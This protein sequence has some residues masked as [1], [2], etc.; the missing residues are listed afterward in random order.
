MA[1]PYRKIS[2]KILKDHYN[3]LVFR[4]GRGNVYLVGG[5]IRDMVRG[6]RS[7]DRDYIVF[8]DIRSFVKQIQTITGGTVVEFKN[9]NMIRIALK[10][11]VT[12]DFSKAQG[13]LEEDLSKRDFTMNAIAWSPE[14]GFRDFHHGRDD[15]KKKMIRS[16]SSANFIAD[17]LRML[18][19]YRFAAE[20]NASIEK[21]TRVMIKRLH[22]GIK[23]VSPERITLEFFKLLNSEGSA[24]YLRMALSDGV[25]QDI[26][27]FSYNVL[28]RSIRAVSKLERASITTG[29]TTLKVLLKKRFS[30]TLTYKGLL[31]L[32]SVFACLD[33]PCKTMSSLVLSNAIQARIE[34]SS[35]GINEVRVKK[36]PDK[37]QLFDIFMSAKEASVDSMII[38]NRIDLLRDYRRFLRILHKGL[39]SSEEIINIS[40]IDAGPQRGKIIS[41]VKKAQFA[42]RLKSKQQAL[43]MIKEMSK[44]VTTAAQ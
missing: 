32:E 30:Q 17:P 6:V 21:R 1:L 44:S 24:K 7:Y 13:S 43:F 4:K 27:S 33:F 26:L 2:Q 15:I 39:L 11:G 38:S 20:L 36:N 41:A 42:G 22:N 34:L 9:E 28:G 10:E 16:L 18:R 14:S 19:A 5:F 12:L 25:L 40:D 35:K 3:A 23:Q 8:G 31:C 29:S 37:E